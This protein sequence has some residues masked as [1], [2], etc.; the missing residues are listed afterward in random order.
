M[1]RVNATFDTK[2]VTI[3]DIKK[4]G[5]MVDVVYIDASNNLEMETF[6]LS[7]SGSPRYLTTKEGSRIQIATSATLA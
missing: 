2:S 6:T 3:V 1:D 7:P 5:A 4:N